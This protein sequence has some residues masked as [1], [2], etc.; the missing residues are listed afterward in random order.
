MLL[1][2]L[3]SGALVFVLISVF[4]GADAAG[5]YVDA[6]AL[7]SG[8]GK[9]W[10]NAFTTIQQG[11]NAASNGD[12]VTVAQGTYVENI[13]FRGK[14]IGLRSM[15]P[16]N[17]EVT[18]KTIIDGNKVGSVVTFDGSEDETCALEGFT[19]CNGM[20]YVGGGI[21]GGAG[22]HAT[23]RYN[24]IMANSAN[25]NGGGVASCH[26]L[27]E[28]NGIGGNAAINF[29]GGGLSDCGGTIRYNVIYAN[30]A[31]MGAGLSECYG[32]TI[33]GN[34]IS[35]NVATLGGGG[36]SDCGDIIENNTISGNTGD[37]FGGG[38]LVGCEGTFRNNIIYGNFA[39]FGGGG[40]FSGCGGL[41][42]NNIIAGNSAGWAGGGAFE[43]CDGD[44]LNN[45]VYGN[46]SGFEGGGFSG[47]DGTIRNCI[48]WANTALEGNEQLSD[49]TPPTY[50]CIQ[51]WTEGGEGNISVEPRFLDTDKLNFRL[52]PSSPCIDVGLSDPG[53][54]ATDRVGMHR[55]MYGGKALTVDMGVHEFYIN[56]V[57][58]VPDT[59]E[60]ILTWSSLADKTY[61]IFYSDDLLTWQLIV[62][63]F[64]SV[65]DQTTSWTDDGSLTGLP[66]SL[67]PRR[68][69]RVLE[70]P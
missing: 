34:V 19:I 39:S 66:P 28:L 37:V 22:T 23:I 16:T 43:G 60:A 4:S 18:A 2:P 24:I 51:D 7:G 49:C 45:T 3:R 32:G 55:I 38:G 62:E 6:S 36:L 31:P 15:D 57:E 40:A 56:E 25:S 50:S 11:V 5:W 30:L 17:V 61:S 58:P 41:F 14:N 46:S 67:A 21:D 26:G 47:C 54:P 9:T 63:N 44:F 13:Q 70:N 35:D 20:T 52:L 48:I 59:N 29:D 12:T 68:F 53:L 64:P 33:D 42:Q 65:G 69:Y 8:D 27:I 10:Q 1:R